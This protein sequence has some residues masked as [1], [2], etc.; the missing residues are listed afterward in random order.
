ML[1]T[2]EVLVALEYLHMLEIVYRDLKPENVLVKSDGHIMLSDFD[3][4]LCSD[5]IAAV[6]SPS[7]SP[8]PATT[9]SPSHACALLLPLQPALPVTQ[10][11][12]A[13]SCSR[14]LTSP[15]APMRSCPLNLHLIPQ[16]P[17]PH[18]ARP[19]PAPFS[20]L[21]NRLFRSRKVQTLTLN[22]HFVAKQV[23]TRS[24][25]FVGTHEFISPE[26]KSG[27]SHGNA[28]DWLAFEIF[29]YEMISGRTPFVA[30]SNETTLRSII[31]K[32]LAKR[33]RDELCSVGEGDRLS[34]RCRC[35]RD[36]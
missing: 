17:R 30:P 5:T 31:K 11:R 22:R 36:S 29:V 16:I 2:A 23:G 15:F 35:V 20:C 14:T 10:D 27:G 7:Y 4:S 24:C 19:T 18:R 3:L 6:E 21:S 26:V 28:V 34:E 8:D 25:S 1:P 33:E 9:P 32:P 13:T 12:T